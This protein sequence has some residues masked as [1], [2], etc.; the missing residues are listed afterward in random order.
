MYVCI[1]KYNMLSPCGVA[2]VFVFKADCLG[3]DTLSG[4]SSLVNTGS[5]LPAS[6]H[7]LGVGPCE[8]STLLADLSTSHSTGERVMEIYKCAMEFC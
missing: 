2:P 3:V 8:I 6:S 7:C 4:W 1:Y 5:L